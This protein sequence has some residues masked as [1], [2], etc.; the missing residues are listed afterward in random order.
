MS[1]GQKRSALSYI[2][3]YKNNAV[4]QLIILSGVAYVMLAVTWALIMIVYSGSDLA[5][6]DY[7]VPN[8]AIGSLTAFKGHWWTVFTYGWFLYPNSFWELLS[9]MLWLYCFG[10]VVQMLVGPKQ[11]IPLYAYCLVTA[12]IFYVIA[13]LL[14]GRMGEVN[15]VLLG[16]RAGLMG[17]AVAAVALTPNYRFYLTEKFSIPLMI[18]AGVFVM[19]MLIGAG[20]SFPVY[21]YLAAGGGMGFVYVRL[22]R[23]GYRPAEWAYQVIHKI[24]SLVTP[25]QKFQQKKITLSTGRRGYEPKQGIS[26]RRIDDILDKINQKGYNSLTRDEKEMLL[27]AGRE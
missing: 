17:M 20:L 21:I 15:S 7:F 18:V 5:F 14:P 3:G 9:N 6:K 12:G 27:R 16:G 25:S 19:L 26:Q 4:L 2:P 1:T 10:S 22:L 11:V 24:E 13:Q 23:A 8:I